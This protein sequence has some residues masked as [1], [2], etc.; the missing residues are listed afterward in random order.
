MQEPMLRLNGVNENLK[1]RVETT[2][3]GPDSPGKVAKALH[4]LFP[5]F[6]IPHPIIEPEL[7]SANDQHWACDQVPLDH[8][9]QQLHRQQILDTA[10]DYMSTHYADGSTMFTLSRQ[11]ALA[12]KVAFP[13]PTEVPLG[14]VITVHLE[15]ETLA[16]WLE[17][18]TWH[19]GRDSVPKSI[20]DDR[21]MSGD[22]EA[23]T[24]I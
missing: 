3:Q 2:L 6:A 8:F 20:H 13:L 12:G 18:A 23:V 21:T 22:G 15:G 10:L 19:R 7:G 14:G 11:A 16:D 17:A 5:E 9:I 24:W 1:I 4:A